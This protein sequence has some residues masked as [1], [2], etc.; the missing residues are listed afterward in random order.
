MCISEWQNDFIHFA[1]HIYLERVWSTGTIIKK[2]INNIKTYQMFDFFEKVSVY[3]RICV[4]IMTN[5]QQ[6]YWNHWYNIS[7]NLIITF[8][9][10]EYSNSI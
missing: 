1:R 6:R 7:N 3:V 10:C 5:L 2:I 9:Q 4:I 8:M